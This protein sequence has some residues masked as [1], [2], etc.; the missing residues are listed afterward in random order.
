MKALDNNEKQKYRYPESD[1]NSYARLFAAVTTS[2]QLAVYHE[3]CLHLTGKVVDCGCGSAKIAPFL[4]DNEQVSHYTGVDYSAEMVTAAEWVI[5]T[6]EREQFSVQHCKIEDATGLYDSA[7]SIQ[8][9]YSWPEPLVTLKHIADLL[10]TGGQFV[11]ASPNPSLSLAKL[12]KDAR[13]EL[14]AHPDFQAFQDYN[15]QLAA[16]PQ[17]NFISMDDLIK[18][19]QQVGFEVLE[20]HQQHFQGGLNFLVLRKKYS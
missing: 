20:C 4:A 17:A 2:M 6:L 5:S 13:K 11:L 10:V 12:A 7:V 19:T 3:A 16:N 1:W 9:Y 15:L 8:S 14:V 18:Q